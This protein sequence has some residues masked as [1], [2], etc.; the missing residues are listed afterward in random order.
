M[1]RPKE[2]YKLDLHV[3][4]KMRNADQLMSAEVASDAA[5]LWLLVMSYLRGEWTCVTTL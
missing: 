3:P 4:A 1:Q 2:I 5:R